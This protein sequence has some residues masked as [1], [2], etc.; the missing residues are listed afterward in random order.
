MTVVPTPEELVRVDPLIAHYVEN[1]ALVSTFHKSLLVQFSESEAL[2]KLIHSTRS[3]LK[4]PDHLRKK[5]VRKLREAFSSGTEFGVTKENLFETINDLAGIRILHLHTTQAQKIDEQMKAIFAE[6]SID[7]VEGPIARTWDD[8]YR[9][10]FESVGIGTQ[11]SETMY[12]SIHYVVA[13]KSK[14]TITCEIQVRTLME[15]VWGEVNH[16]INYPDPNDHVACVE[17][18]RALARSTSA[19]TRLVDSIFATVD[20]IQKKLVAR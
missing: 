3:R 17:Q 10:Y 6:Q 9:S 2:Q 16:S 14:K 11:K 12:T 13:S 5:L 20:D 15:E 8:E 19:A 18:I 7:I 1:K 4:D